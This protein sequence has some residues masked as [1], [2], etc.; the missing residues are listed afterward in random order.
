MALLWPWGI[1]GIALGLLAGYTVLA[2]VVLAFAWREL[3][4][5][6]R[7]GSVA[8][9]MALNLGFMGLSRGFVLLF[10]GPEPFLPVV[11]WL[12]G[13]TVAYVY[14]SHRVGFIWCLELETTGR[15]LWRRW[16]LQQG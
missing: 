1:R 6:M 10:P 3:G 15:L 9:T 13:V 16:Q 12:M 14:I 2:T 8:A 11:L 7:W 4:F 5:R